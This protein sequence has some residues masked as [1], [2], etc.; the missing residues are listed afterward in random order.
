VTTVAC[1]QLAPVIGELEHNRSLGAK[2]VARA[3]AAGAQVLV[4]PELCTSGYVFADADEAAR[5]AESLDGPAVRSWQALSAERGMVVVAGLCEALGDGRLGNSA[6]VLDGGEILAV[7]RKTHL[8]DREKLI[9]AAGDEPP[10]VV[11]TSAG[12]I[13]VVI[14]Y[15]AFF[16]E[17]MRSLALR[18]A[19]LIAAPANVPV[20]GPVLEPLPVEVVAAVAAAAQNRVFVAQCDRD[21]DERGVSWVGASAI[22]DPDGRLLARG[23]GVLTAQVDLARARD[24]RWNDRNDALGDRRPELYR[25]LPRTPAATSP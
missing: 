15:D 7:Y 2:A 23:D 9:F 14:C 18:G 10:P 24:K 22:I 5:C 25:P 11:A 8:W 19:E 6:V 3:A 1:A 21:G 20:L 12:R 16:P 13:G 4:L 17:L